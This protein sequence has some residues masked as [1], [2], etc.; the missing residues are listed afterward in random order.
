[1]ATVHNAVN[2]NQAVNC[3]KSTITYVAGANK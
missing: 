1:M 2:I 3:Q